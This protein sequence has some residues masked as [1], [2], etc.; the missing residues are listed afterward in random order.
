M[1]P[2]EFRAHRKRMGLSQTAL[3]G[4]FGV[5]ERTIRRYEQGT[6]RIPRLVERWM[7][8]QG[9]PE[10]SPVLWMANW[11]APQTTPPQR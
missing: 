6:S 4:L 1:T 2:A 5:S 7:Q 8:V 3:A 11:P 10:R 9:W